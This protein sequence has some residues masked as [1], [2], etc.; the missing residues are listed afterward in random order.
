M[1]RREERSLEELE[2]AL[3]PL[4][5]GVHQT[6]CESCWQHLEEGTPDVAVIQHRG[7][8][9]CLRCLNL[10]EDGEDVCRSCTEELA[11]AYGIGS[12]QRSG[13]DRP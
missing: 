1:A 11:R 4:M 6:L 3:K 2:K 5:E 12:D 10:L 9:K 8:T 13:R 7:Q